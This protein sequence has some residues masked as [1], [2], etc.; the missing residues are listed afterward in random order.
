MIVQIN[1]PQLTANADPAMPILNTPMQRYS[2]GRIRADMTILSVMLVLIFPQ[3]RRKLS[4]A[5]T[6]VVKGEA[7]AYTLTYRMASSASSPSAPIKPIRNGAKTQISA[8]EI[9][10]TM[11]IIRQAQVK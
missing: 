3:M 1:M 8:P 2:S 10:P 11:K 4:V 7:R 6:M 9:M 5:K